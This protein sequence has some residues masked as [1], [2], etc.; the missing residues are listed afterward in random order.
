M[1]FNKDRKINGE[2]PYTLD[3]YIDC[4]HGIVIKEPRR[5]VP[6]KTTRTLA[7]ERIA[8]NKKINSITTFTGNCCLP[9]DSYKDEARRKYTVAIPYNKGGYTVIPNDD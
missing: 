6:L 2:R 5:F 9:D 4:I 1:P 8:A 3:E 7:D